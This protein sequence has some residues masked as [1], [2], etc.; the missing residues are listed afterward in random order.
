[1]QLDKCVLKDEEQGDGDGDCDS[2]DE[3]DF[4]V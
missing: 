2:G 3:C 1:M 4:I